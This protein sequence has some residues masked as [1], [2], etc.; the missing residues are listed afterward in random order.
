M[1]HHPAGS[2]GPEAGPHPRLAALTLL[3]AYLVGVVWLALRPLDVLWVSPANL[4]PLATIR[5]DVERGPGE[6]LRTVG[7]G[8][9]RLAPLGVLLPLLG[10]RLG[11]P[12]FASLIRTGFVG[13]MIALAIE[14]LQTLVPSRV[15][16]VDTVILNTLGIVVTHQLCY[17]LLRARTLGERTGDGVWLPAQRRRSPGRDAAP[18][19]RMDQGRTRRGVAALA[20]HGQGPLPAGERAL[21]LRGVSRG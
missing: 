20:A 17:A 2:T 14:G 21:S 15:A 6:A 16:D 9:L 12:R 18:E 4:Q 3:L 13:G 5:A 8:M 19:R 10:K 7:A 1:Q 11:G